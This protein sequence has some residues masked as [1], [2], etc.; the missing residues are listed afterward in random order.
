MHYSNKKKK[1]CIKKCS[2]KHCYEHVLLRALWALPHA[3]LL[4]SWP[5]LILFL[6]LILPSQKNDLGLG[7]PA[8][9]AYSSLSVCTTL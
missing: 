2:L 7:L 6:L 8:P 1:G 5:H 9:A 4:S 3:V